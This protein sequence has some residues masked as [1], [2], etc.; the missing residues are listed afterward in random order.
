MCFLKFDFLGDPR[1]HGKLFRSFHTK[2]IIFTLYYLQLVLNMCVA[3]YQ[4]IFY[5]IHI[6]I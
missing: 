2:N 6:L 3:F 5:L 1:D 4:V